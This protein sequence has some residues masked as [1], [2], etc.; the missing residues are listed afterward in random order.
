MVVITQRCLKIL[1]LICNCVGPIT[2]K[3]IAD[4]LGISERT[5][6]YDLSL[7]RDWLSEKNFDLKSVPKKGHYF[8]ENDKKTCVCAA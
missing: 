8:E 5:T 2:V 6:R 3:Q 7:L 1:G 4:N